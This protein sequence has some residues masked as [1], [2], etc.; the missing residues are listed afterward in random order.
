MSPE[1][2]DTSSGPP[3]SNYTAIPLEL[4]QQILESLLFSLLDDTLRLWA[5]LHNP[6]KQSSQPAH[7]ADDDAELDSDSQRERESESARKVM[8]AQNPL[9]ATLL[10]L[11][12]VSPGM[13]SDLLSPLQHL[14]AHLIHRWQHLLTTSHVRLFEHL[15]T[16]V[17]SGDFAKWLDPASRHPS[18]MS[19]TLPRRKIATVKEALEYHAYDLD[20]YYQQLATRVLYEPSG[21]VGKGGGMLSKCAIG[22][23][24]VLRVGWR[25]GV[26]IGGRARACEGKE[27][28]MGTEKRR[29][30]SIEVDEYGQDG[31]E[32]WWDSVF[33]RRLTVREVARRVRTAKEGVT[34]R[35]S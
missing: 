31:F 21:Q 33:C 19:S 24:G 29:V 26:S 6:D 28:A 18:T 3:R 12:E 23:Q 35:E 17:W 15:T 4:R 27:G 1:A 20:V 13:R 14:S 25:L 9:V 5:G 8:W 11:S 34:S 32:E 16:Q 2:S 10:R 30:V 7:P 22:W